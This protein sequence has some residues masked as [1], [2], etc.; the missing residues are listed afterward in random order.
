MLIFII[1]IMFLVISD[2]N[3][4]FIFQILIFCQ[5]AKRYY[6]HPLSHLSTSNFL[7]KKKKE[8]TLLFINHDTP[9]NVLL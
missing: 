3:A 4:I 9:D 8:R 2:K 7:S 6:L 5:E 1:I